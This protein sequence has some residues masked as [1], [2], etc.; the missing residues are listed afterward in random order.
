MADQRHNIEVNAL[1]DALAARH[2]PVDEGFVSGKNL[3]VL[4]MGIL[5]AVGVLLWNNAT[6]Q[7]VENAQTF[8]VI[9]QQ[10]AETRTTVLE[11]RSMLNGINERLESNTKNTA[12][13]QSAVA[14]MKTQV[15]A[16]SARLDRIEDK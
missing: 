10:T 2:K 4:V 1:I 16:Q 3:N 14:A 11:M 9:Q 15:D 5:G 6:S 13:L 7:P 8:A 12:D